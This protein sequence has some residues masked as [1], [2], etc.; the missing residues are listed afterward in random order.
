MTGGREEMQKLKVTSLTEE[1]CLDIQPLIIT[2]QQARPVSGNSKAA[3]RYI[4]CVFPVFICSYLTR[5]I[6]PLISASG[7]AATQY[8]MV[9]RWEYQAT[10]LGIE[11]YFCHFDI[12]SNLFLS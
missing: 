4:H 9:S 5:I 6:R 2:S 8:T 7:P 10:A 3:A 1:K 12:Q 11:A